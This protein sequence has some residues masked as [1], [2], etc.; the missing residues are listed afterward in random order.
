MLVIPGSKMKNHHHRT[1][2][3]PLVPEAC[4]ILLRSA[5]H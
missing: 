5:A 2:R 4:E 1:H 3:L